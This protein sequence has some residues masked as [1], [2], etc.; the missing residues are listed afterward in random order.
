[1]AKGDYK[2]R[3]PAGKHHLI[4]FEGSAKCDTVAAFLPELEK[5]LGT[6]VRLCATGGHFLS[7]P[8]ESLGIAIDYENGKFDPKYA[9]APDKKELVESLRGKISACLKSGGQLLILTDNDRA[10]EFIAGEIITH[11][12]LK[13][14]TDCLRAG[15]ISPDKRDVFETLDK[16]A[17]ALNVPLMLSEKARLVLD[18]CFGYVQSPHLWNL[19]ARTSPADVQ[20]MSDSLMKNLASF[21][22]LNKELL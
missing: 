9:V 13:L 12:K 15:L 6:K 10:G 2:D 4:V 11:F 20:K 7:T 16:L 21:K 14:G 17:P 22:E 18:K 3:L 5:K 19:A 1:M 8:K